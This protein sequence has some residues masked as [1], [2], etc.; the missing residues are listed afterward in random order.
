MNHSKFQQ[1]KQRFIQGLWPQ[2]TIELSELQHVGENIYA[3]DNTELPAENKFTASYDRAIGISNKQRNIVKEA[4]GETG[5]TNYRNYINVASNLVKPKTVVVIASPESHQLAE[6]IPVVDE[7]IA[8]AIF[9]D[10]AEILA[11]ETNYN[12]SDVSYDNTAKPRITIIYTNPKGET[13]NFGSKEEFIMDGFYIR[14]SPANVELGHYYE[15]LVCS[16]GQIVKE[17]QKD[18]TV[19][20]LSSNEIHNIIGQVKDKSFFINGIEQFGNLLTRASNSRISLAE[21]R[22]AQK[23]LLDEKVSGEQAE[24]LI[25]YA[26]VCSSYQSAGLYDQKKEH[27]IKGEGTIWDT[28]N[29]LTKFASHTTIWEPND[30][31]RITL[32]NNAVNLLKRD[33]DIINYID[34]Y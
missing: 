16:N 29:V 31:R 27:L 18:A 23:M 4:S 13:H 10:F 9:F 19:Y 22:K 34:I 30:H 15:R 12:I 14:W 7:Y 33:P 3:I 20:K 11:D 28:Y 21:M 24:Q 26:T 6:I 32:M 8:P 5:L 25:P 2:K 17:E 1:E